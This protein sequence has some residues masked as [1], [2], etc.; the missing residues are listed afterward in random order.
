MEERIKKLEERMKNLEQKRV[1]QLD[2]APGQV[3]NAAM[4]EANSWFLAG[5]AA[6]LPIGAVV[7]SSVTYYFATDT[8]TL[9]IWNGN[10][11]KSVVLT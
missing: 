10:A 4:G 1:S 2:I 3:K 9:Y 11:Y 6:D 8:N 7:T 5:L